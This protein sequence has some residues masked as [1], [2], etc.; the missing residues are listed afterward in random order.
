LFE[1]IVQQWPWSILVQQWSQLCGMKCS[2]TAKS[3]SFQSC[4]FFLY[5]FLPFLLYSSFIF[6]NLS[7]LSISFPL[8]LFSCFIKSM[9][10]FWNNT[11]YRPS[12]YVMHLTQYTYH[13]TKS[14]PATSRVKSL[15]GEKP[16]VSRTISALVLR[17]LKSVPCQFNNLTRLVAR[18]DFIMHSRRD[19]CRSYTYR[20][21]A[22]PLNNQ[23][24][25]FHQMQ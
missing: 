24:S 23:D 16:K 13:I 10:F 21:D 22:V 15:N 7:Y 4:Y 6:L 5:C 17:V 25:Q 8:C 11:S 14:S 1:N 19:S 9:T 3:T 2:P 12:P 20:T 18:E